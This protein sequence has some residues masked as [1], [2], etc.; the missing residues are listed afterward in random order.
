MD[1]SAV[2]STSSTCSDMGTSVSAKVAAMSRTVPEEDD[3][4]WLDDG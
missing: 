4:D 2:R 1:V 3:E